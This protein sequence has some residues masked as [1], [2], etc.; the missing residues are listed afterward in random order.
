MSAVD[1][2]KAGWRQRSARD[3]FSPSVQST[4]WNASGALE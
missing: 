4:L 1:N 3:G 2:L